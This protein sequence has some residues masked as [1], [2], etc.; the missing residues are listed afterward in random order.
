MFLDNQPTAVPQA[1]ATQAAE[2]Y[3]VSSRAKNAP[4]TA[5][6]NMAELRYAQLT[7]Y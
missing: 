1:R 4:L 2:A 6:P 7:P 5:D 3:Q